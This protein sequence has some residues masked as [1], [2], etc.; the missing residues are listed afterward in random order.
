MAKKQYSVYDWMQSTPGFLQILGRA[1]LFMSTW[2]IIFDSLQQAFLDIL[3]NRMA[4][5]T[6]DSGTAIIQEFGLPADEV[7]TYKKWL[8][9]SERG[10]KQGVFQIM[11]DLGHPNV[12]IFSGNERYDS[13]FMTYNTS[14]FP[15][16]LTR[17]NQND[18]S[19]SQFDKLFSNQNTN[20]YLD[21]SGLSN[22]WYTV[23]IWDG[24]SPTGAMAIQGNVIQGSQ[25]LGW[26]N[27][28]QP[29]SQLTGAQ[30]DPTYNYFGLTNQSVLIDAAK[31][32]KN[33]KNV[34]ME[35]IICY[36][37]TSGSAQSLIN[38]S[39]DPV[40]VP[41]SGNSWQGDVIERI[42]L[43]PDDYSTPTFQATIPLNSGMFGPT[44]SLAGTTITISTYEKIKPVQY[45]LSAAD[46][47]TQQD[48]LNLFSTQ[49]NSS[50][51][52]KWPGMFATVDSDNTLILQ[53]AVN[54]GSNYDRSRF[55]ATYPFNNLQDLN[56][57][58]NI[59][60]LINR[61]FPYT[62]FQAEIDES[63]N[64]VVYNH[65]PYGSRAGMPGISGI[66][67]LGTKYPNMIQNSNAVNSLVTFDAD[68]NL[69]IFGNLFW[70]ADPYLGVTNKI[71]VIQST[72]W[73]VINKNPV[74]VIGIG[75]ANS[76]LGLIP[77]T[78][79]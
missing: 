61:A 48:F 28:R 75:T 45:A 16:S 42:R 66:S 10:T 49:T 72:A 21:S 52:T 70:T 57:I 58:K 26:N 7:L 14:S 47:A 11:N 36:P 8:Y 18:T 33:I 39:G 22:N 3:T 79:K 4:R 55:I 73:P 35:L 15:T 56:T 43:S 60:A 38:S 50:A 51:A 5:N 19:F 67:L 64:L 12:S 78:Y 59:K 46:V 25:P 63:N 54:A 34:P 74:L 29:I 9:T 20:A 76:I 31:W 65:G 17:Y 32:G 27:P 37:N 30:V 69:Y 44:G 77:N 40:T 23:V 68:G 53:T 62:L 41:S 13:P 71:G 6:S 2:G 1:K 24:Y